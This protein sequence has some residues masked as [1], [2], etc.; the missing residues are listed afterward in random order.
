MP[1]LVDIRNAH[2]VA[3][4]RGVHA[5]LCRHLLELP[6]AQVAIERIPMGDALACR[7]ELGRRDEVDVEPA[8]TVVIEQR[9][10]AAA[11]LQDVVFRRP[12]AVRARGQLHGLLEG[13]RCGR[14][15]IVRCG[16]DAGGGSHRGRVPTVCRFLRRSLAI[17]ALERQTEGDLS[18]DLHAHAFEQ[19]QVPARVEAPVV[20]GFRRRGQLARGAAQLGTQLGREPRRS[21]GL[22]TSGKIGLGPKRVESMA[23]LT[24]GAPHI[25]PGAIRSR[26][27]LQQAHRL[28]VNREQWNARRYTDLLGPRRRH[29]RGGSAER[30][31]RGAPRKA[32]P[33]RWVPRGR[34]GRRMDNRH[35]SSHSGPDWAH[36]RHG[37]VRRLP[38][39]TP[40]DERRSS[41]RYE[42]KASSRSAPTY[43]SPRNPSSRAF[44]SLAAA[45]TRRSARVPSRPRPPGGRPSQ[46]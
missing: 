23:R 24:Q 4:R 9:H 32:G 45:G 3:P 15:L 38:S 6:S 37:S 35:T 27:S 18:L 5:R 16:R 40:S 21:W 22:R 7:A 34:A 41:S 8:V 44:C 11:R 10:P 30:Q 14:R 43:F 39:G 17:A 13:G 31:Q 12:A 36:P 42:R 2:A 19:R 29:G 33:R 25:I 28:A 1:I 46:V 20:V 26:G